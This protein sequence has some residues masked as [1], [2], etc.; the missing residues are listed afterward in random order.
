MAPRFKQLLYQIYDGDK[1]VSAL[2]GFP[3]NQFDLVLPFRN[4][5]CVE[6]EKSTGLSLWKM[7]GS[8]YDIDGRVIFFKAE[9]AKVVEGFYS[10]PWRGLFSWLFRT[11]YYKEHRA[12]EG[13]VHGLINIDVD[14]SHDYPRVAIYSSIHSMQSIANAI[15]KVAEN[16][17]VSIIKS[18]FNH[19]MPEIL[20]SN[21]TYG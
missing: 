9:D 21:R 18:D 8:H 17:N 11:R 6:F 2:L 15:T 20:T 4:G 19:T 13:K 5:L 16:L 12:E 14:T 3:V 7:P 10:K 1:N